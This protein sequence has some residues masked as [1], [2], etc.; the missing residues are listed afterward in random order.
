MALK[1]RYSLLSKVNLDN[2]YNSFISLSPQGRVIALSVGG[3]IL[4]LLIF[5][6]TS[7]MSGKIASL[8]KEIS[9]SQESLRQISD[10]LV[11]YQDLKASVEE[12]E[13][14]F[15]VGV[16]SLA[17]SIEG[18]AT[19]SNVRSN[20]DSLRGK[21]AIDTDD[22]TGEAVELRLSKLTLSQLVDFLYNVEQ[23]TAGFMKVTKIEIRP[24]YSNRSLMDV[25]C[26]IANFT[27][28]KGT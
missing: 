9:T 10:K 5:L 19:K 18:I 23:N 12:M 20:M 7:L 27:L 17:T 2:I 3:F 6:P 14:S 25:S 1:T 28:K 24:M 16:G 15:G 26:E 21:P 4:V 13:R 22:L 11:E 8:Q